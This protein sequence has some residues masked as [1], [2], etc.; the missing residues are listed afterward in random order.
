MKWSLLS[1][2]VAGFFLWGAISGLAAELHIFAA[3]SLS[4]SLSE[5]SKTY[6]KKSGHK[7]HGNYGAS[8][9][10]ARQIEEGAPADL[11][12]SADEAKVDRLAKLGFILPA[13]RTNLLSN[14]LV[15]VVRKDSTLKLTSPQLLADKSI[16]RVALAQPETVP[17]GIYAR[18]YLMQQK[19]WETVQSKVVPMD[20]VR[21]ALAAVESGNADAGI[22][23][24]TD[25]AVGRDVIVAYEVP[26]QDNPDIRYPLVMLRDSKNP[27][28]A[29]QFWEF[30]TSPAAAREFERHGFL[31][32]K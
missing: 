7:V 26:P 25:V 32:P 6:E 29:R 16:R 19:L 23:Y 17:A 27:Q 21:A 20:N 13:T 24:K 12:F 1:L 8:S 30:L 14:R 22:V 2:T 28:A 3:A 9:F 4:D 18:D 31:T 11:F 10:L 15:I 5:L